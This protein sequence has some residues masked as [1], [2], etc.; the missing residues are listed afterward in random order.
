MKSLLKLGFTKKGIMMSVAAISMSVI[1]ILVWFGYDVRYDTIRQ[2]E[3]E[4]VAYVTAEFSETYPSTYINLDGDV[5]ATIETDYWSEAAS[6][7]Y[8]FITING[9]LT[10]SNGVLNKWSSEGW[11]MPKMPSHWG[12]DKNLRNRFDFD[13][14]KYHMQTKLTVNAI[15]ADSYEDHSFTESTN[16]NLL[17]ISKVDEAVE[18][19]TWWGISYG[20]DF[21]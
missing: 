13:G 2:C 15:N 16:K 7:V 9:V 19:K 18:V 14:Y 4:S 5:V 3:V 17:C 10:K 21:Y 12:Y 1:Y 11:A 8:V 6:D 20:S